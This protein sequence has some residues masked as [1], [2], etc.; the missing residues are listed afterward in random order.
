MATFAVDDVTVESKRDIPA[1][2]LWYPRCDGNAKAIDVGLADVR[3]SDG[4]RVTYD[5]DRDGWSIQQASTFSW[6][7]DDHICDADYQE[8]AFVQSWARDNERAAT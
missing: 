1:V 6:D 5:F 3:A 7:V 8:V 4:I 2:E